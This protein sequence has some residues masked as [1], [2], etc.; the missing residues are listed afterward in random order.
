M[1]DLNQE[2]FRSI[3]NELID[4][5]AMACRGLLGISSLE[6][7]E[8]V[9]TASVSL[10]ERPVLRVN[11]GFVAK[12]CRTESEV[13]ALLVH[14]FL[15]VLL[16]HTMEIRRM[17]PSINI[18]LDATINAIIHRKLGEEYSSF[19]SRYYAKAE[20][21]LLLLRPK[22]GD[23][24]INE[25][26]V[27]H[28]DKGCSA[29]LDP[30]RRASIDWLGHD[31]CA[32]WSAIYRGQAL[33]EDALELIKARKVEG[34][35]RQFT[36][37]HPVFLGNHAEDEI[38]DCDDLPGDLLSRLHVAASEMAAMGALPPGLARPPGDLTVPASRLPGIAAWERKTLALLRRLIVPD[39]R[40][41]VSET[42]PAWSHL[43]ILHQSDRR[44]IL[45]SLWNPL[46]AENLWPA[47]LPLR[48]GS[49]AVY[50]DVS[51]SMGADLVALTALLHRFERYLIRPF[52]A[53]A[54]T[55]EP[56]TISNGKLVTR[57][58]GGTSLAC[59]IE[60]LRRVRPEKALVVTDGYVEKLGAA[61]YA[62]PGIQVEVLLSPKGIVD[63]L[64]PSRWPIHRL[65]AR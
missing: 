64:E 40:T 3:L 60:H 62:L 54:N 63:S 45:R 13:K 55:V 23:D 15:H 19:M 34:L 26:R 41:R 50:L 37:G 53:F 31:G 2:A 20:G 28:N 10:G 36:A 21:A 6:F 11:L 27:F 16:R 30:E 48:G 4:E 61:S 7:T 32:L 5:N 22:S 42:Q 51:G 9:D 59:V 52:W 46:I 17:T 25:R 56:A 35:S 24:L 8:Q 1:K 33:H 49:V 39:R 58:T 29:E 44:G 43:P 65:S 18:A 57:S 47:T 14:E 12:H 38:L